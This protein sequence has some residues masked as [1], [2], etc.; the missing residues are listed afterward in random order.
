M[1]TPSISNAMTVT[2]GLLLASLTAA[3]AG[4][5]PAEQPRQD[6]E[7]PVPVAQATEVTGCLRGGSSAGTH[8][9]VTAPDPMG[10]SV[11]R[12][13][14]GQVATYTY[15]LVGE[16]LDQHV[17]RQVAVTGT[18]EATDDMKVEETREQAAAPTEVNGDTVTPTVEVEETAVIEMRRLRVASVQPTGEA[19]ATAE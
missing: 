6:A 17:G 12:S 11:D 7:R 19:C 16:Q 2:A 10:A 14:R 9:L 3:C 5:R 18:I 13:T 15:L 4:E 1:T 8:V